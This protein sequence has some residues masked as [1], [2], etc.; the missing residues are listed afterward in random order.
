MSTTSVTT[1][2]LRRPCL[3]LLG[4]VAL[5][6]ATFSAQPPP[7][8]A[9]N[10]AEPCEAP[11]PGGTLTSVTR[12]PAGV[13]F[14]GNLSIQ[15]KVPATVWGHVTYG[16]VT[17]VTTSTRKFDFTIPARSGNQVCVG[18]DSG[19]QTGTIGCRCSTSRSIRLERSKWRWCGIRRAVWT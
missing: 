11:E 8:H 10:V 5:G 12:V 14:Q 6:F 18:V 13:R 16:P 4:A 17:S 1:F 19:G 3:A 7:A 2:G 15:T 9:C